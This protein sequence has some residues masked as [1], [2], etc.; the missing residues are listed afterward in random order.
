MGV[1]AAATAARARVTGVGPCITCGAAD[2]D[3]CTEG[4]P[5]PPQRTV[6]KAEALAGFARW[7]GA[8]AVLLRATEQ[9]PSSHHGAPPARQGNGGT[10]EPPGG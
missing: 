8:C 1:C 6:T 5:L 2:H 3:W 9:L 4:V 7:L 10:H